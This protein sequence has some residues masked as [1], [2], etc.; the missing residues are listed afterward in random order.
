MTTKRGRPKGDPLEL[1]EQELRVMCYRQAGI[2]TNI[3]ATVLK[4]SVDRVYR[5]ERKARKKMKA[6][7]NAQTNRSL[8]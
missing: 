1:T 7:E 4:V 6:R 8:D 5:I 2:T 3:I